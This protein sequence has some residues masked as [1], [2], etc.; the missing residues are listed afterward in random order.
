V[1]R[2]AVKLRKSW[3]INPATKVKKSKKV[4]SRHR[5]KLELKRITNGK[6]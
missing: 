6:E 4:Y 1:Q 2:K 3:V 5:L